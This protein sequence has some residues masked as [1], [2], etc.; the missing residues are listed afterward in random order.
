M[1]T[2]VLESLEREQAEELI[3]KCGGKISKSI[4]KN[5]SYVVVGEEA[6]PKKLETAKN[7]GTPQLSEDDLLELIR[8]KSQN[9]TN[10]KNKNDGKKKSSPEKP[11]VE[12]KQTKSIK[13]AN[14]VKKK[15]SPEKSKVENNDT[16]SIKTEN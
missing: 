3:K 14:D 16:K 6:G 9:G 12:N 8:T 10:Q 5:T 1:G 2:G 13:V 15:S 4:S 11:K 7:L